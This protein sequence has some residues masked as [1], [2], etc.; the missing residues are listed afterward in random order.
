MSSR[1]R[2]ACKCQRP[3]K[4]EYAAKDEKRRQGA[5]QCQV[6]SKGIS[7][8]EASSV[9]RPGDEA[10]KGWRQCQSKAEAKG[11]QKMLDCPKACMVMA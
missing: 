10:I 2:S 11:P 6:D 5:Q 3:G 8:A 1:Q 4:H 7:P 9:L